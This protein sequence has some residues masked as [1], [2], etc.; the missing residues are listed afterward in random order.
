MGLVTWNPTVTG[1][2]W[3]NAGDQPTRTTDFVNLI[4]PWAHYEVSFSKPFP[5]LA[6]INDPL[7]YGLNQIIAE[8]RRRNYCILLSCANSSFFP[9]SVVSNVLF[10]KETDRLTKFPGTAGGILRIIRIAVERIRAYEGRTVYPW[11]RTYYSGVLGPGGGME[12][13]YQFRYSD[14]EELRDALETEWILAGNPCKLAAPTASYP[15]SYFADTDPPFP[16]NETCPGAY[17]AREKQ[18]LRIPITADSS[19]SSPDHRRWGWW[20]ENLYISGDWSNNRVGWEVVFEAGSGGVLDATMRWRGLSRIIYPQGLPAAFQQPSSLKCFAEAGKTSYSTPKSIIFNSYAPSPT[21]EFGH[22]NSSGWIRGGAEPLITDCSAMLRVTEPPTGDGRI[23]SGTPAEFAKVHRF[24]WDDTEFQTNPPGVFTDKQLFGSVAGWQE[25]RP[26]LVN[27]L[28]GEHV[29]HNVDLVIREHFNLPATFNGA[30]LYTLSPYI[31]STYY[32]NGYKLIDLDED[33]DGIPSN[34]QG[35]ARVLLTKQNNKRQNGFYRII[36]DEFGQSIYWEC[37][38]GHED[39]AFALC[40]GS[41]SQFNNPVG[42]ITLYPVPVGWPSG[43]TDKERHWTQTQH[44][45]VF[46]TKIFTYTNLASGDGNEIPRYN[47]I[48]LPDEVDVA[49]GPD[50]D[51]DALALPILN[52]HIPVELNVTTHDL[53]GSGDEEVETFFMWA[54]KE[55]VAANS[56]HFLPAGHNQVD[57]PGPRY[58]GARFALEVTQWRLYPA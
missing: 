34:R 2:D 9:P 36:Y 14:I 24:W 7:S 46:G 37:L 50:N 58:G 41:K 31:G 39:D 35:Y 18:G 12:G 21:S 48:N 51:L 33:F 57:P 22:M 32:V 26:N 3:P 44:S 45:V 29:N 38:L 43:E 8:V 40:K 55:E 42:W 49:V 28:Y 23:E 52:S 54:E 47:L 25:W 53:T 56:P 1:T 4:G 13:R 20:A 10:I 19:P 16:G 17:G 27:S 30:Y 11:S 6:E 15:P 5:V